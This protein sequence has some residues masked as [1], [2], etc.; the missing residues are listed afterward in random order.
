M[1]IY[2]QG[3]NFIQQAEV[4]GRL[5]SRL[6]P[7]ALLYQEEDTRPYECDGLVRV[8]RVADGGRA[9]RERGRGAVRP[10]DL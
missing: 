8:S 7:A 3:I 9:A 10:E 2:A 4:V 6:P 5:K 1:N